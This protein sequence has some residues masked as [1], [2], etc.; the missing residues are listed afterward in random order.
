[1]IKIDKNSTIPLYVQ[2][3]NILIEKIQNEMD[4]ND[5]LDSERDICKKYEVSRTTVR[6]ALDELE[7]NKYI[8]KVQGKGNFIFPRVVEQDL[9]KVS[10]FTEEMKKH[11]KKPTSK[12]LNFEIIEA[13]N[14]ISKKL[15]IEENELVFKISRIRIA[16]DTPMMYEITYLPYERFE[17]LTKEM[18]EEVPLYELLKNIFNVNIISAEE[19]I[20]SV[21]INKLESIYLEIPQGQAGLKV[22]RIAYEQKGIIEYTITIARGDKYRYRI[23]LGA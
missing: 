2:L 16:D 9:I 20:E 7:K 19:V 10:S 6:E 23:C 14:K 18:I 15:K 11:G 12:L 17:K 3:M 22:E 4:E 5:K 21:L 13:S 1:M 8:Y